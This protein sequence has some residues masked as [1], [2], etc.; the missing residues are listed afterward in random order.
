MSE[1]RELMA[2]KLVAIMAQNTINSLRAELVAEREKVRESERLLSQE[3][4]DADALLEIIGLHQSG[5][6]DG[7]YINV[8]KAREYQRQTISTL[9]DVKI[10]SNKQLAAEREKVREYE[11]DILR[12]ID[13]LKYIG[14]IAERGRGVKIQDHERVAKVVLDYV[15]KTEQQNALLTLEAKRL[16]KVINALDEMFE[17]DTEEF[18]YAIASEIVYQALATTPLDTSALDAYVAE[19]VEADREACAKVCDDLADDAD[20]DFDAR[21]AFNLAAELIRN[22]PLN[23]GG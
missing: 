14:G 1:S 3:C 11:Q 17:C 23:L 2:G 10:E 8:A 9:M 5:R 12:L 19:K 22:R 20:D 16:R 7:G 4:N 13:D 21:E 18:D 6:T 15:K